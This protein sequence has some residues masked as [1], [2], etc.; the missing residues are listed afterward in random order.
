MRSTQ[1]LQR[2]KSPLKPSALGQPHPEVGGTVDAAVVDAA[3]VG[4]APQGQALLVAAGQVR[5]GGEL[6]EVVDVEG[7]ARHL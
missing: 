2:G 5:G 3:L 6:V 7:V 1:P 4:P